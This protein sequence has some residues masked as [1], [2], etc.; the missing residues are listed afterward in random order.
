[1][2]AVLDNLATFRQGF[3][4][5]LAL[6][7]V[8]A[9]L[10]L[11]LGTLLA[12]MRVSPVP[13]L[14]AAGATY[15]EVVRNTPLTLVFFFAVF[16]LPQLDIRLSFFVFAVIAVTVYHAAFFC[17]AVRSGIN[18]VGVGQAEA[19]R[20]IGL[21]FG[22]SLRLVVLP[23]AFRT[24]IP[25]LINVV[26]ALTKNTSIAGAF[27]VVERA[28]H[29]AELLGEP[30]GTLILTLSA[31]SIEVGRGLRRRPR[32]A[33][34]DE[35]GVEVIANTQVELVHRRHHPALVAHGVAL[36]PQ[37]EHLDHRREAHRA[38]DVAARDV[39]VQAFG[40]QVG[41]DQQDEGQRQHL[42]GR[43]VVDELAQRPRR[44]Q[45]GIGPVD[46][47]IVQPQFPVDQGR[48]AGRGT[49][50]KWLIHKPMMSLGLKQ[51]KPSPMFR[52]SPDIRCPDAALS[53]ETR[54]FIQTEETPNPATL[55]FL[56]GRMVMERGTADFDAARRFDVARPP[57]AFTAGTLYRQRARVGDLGRYEADRMDRV[58]MLHEG[59]V[60]ADDAP[61]APADG[62]ADSQ[63]AAS[64]RGARPSFP[65]G[66]P[67][68]SRSRCRSGS[69]SRR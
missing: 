38:V 41:A 59:N 43:V 62:G 51:V 19:A 20:S 5:T 30:L 24:V 15:V 26:I 64:R 3:V 67:S 23:Q 63:L 65:D 11:L 14:R 22:Q 1:M 48:Q 31:V 49:G 69:R 29:L 45:H 16:V 27:G 40:D 56:P 39:R 34:A 37:V 54:M 8:S 46:R 55:K 6:T 17:E 53:L 35:G 4:T 60:V 52:P 18:A 58:I 32:V 7:V 36:G 33:R 57:L 68:G 50:A 42:D 13:T 9:V 10:A 44:Q 25:P 61:A 47:R 12:A 21:T 66:S 28:E 2:D